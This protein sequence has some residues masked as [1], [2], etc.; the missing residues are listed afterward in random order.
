MLDVSGYD[1]G[2][3]ING[4]I[5]KARP[6]ADARGNRLLVDV[7]S[8]LGHGVGDEYRLGQC[9]FNL[10]ANASKAATESVVTL[11]AETR[12]LNE[13]ETFVI[14]VSDQGPGMSEEAIARLFDPFSHEE[15]PSYADSSRLGLAITRRVA[16]LLGGELVVESAPGAGSRF[17]LHIPHDRRAKA[18]TGPQERA[19]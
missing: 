13:R 17:T 4:A 11:R 16:R 8:N 6:I 15:L 5:A 10:L 19:A 7:D 3:V 12:L 9:V 1:A 14:A 18:R 2:E